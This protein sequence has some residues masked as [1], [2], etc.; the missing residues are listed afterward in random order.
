[1]SSVTRTGAPSRPRI[2]VV[3]IVAALATFWSFG[4]PLD[5][6]ATTAPTYAQMMQRVVD[7][8]NAIRVGVGLRP[9][10]R[11]AALDKVAADWARQQWQNG[12]MS[13]NPNF[14]TQIPSGW[15]RAGENVAKGYT[16][17][18]VV[19]A[20]KASSGHY[21]NIVNDYNSIGIGYFEQDGRRYWTQLFAKYPGVV[22]P[23]V[24][25]TPPVNTAAPTASGSRAIGSSWT[26]TN[27]T[28]TGTP[29]PSLQRTW[30]RCNQ[31]VTTASAAVPAGCAVISGATSAIYRS[32]AADAG[33]YLTV[34]I[35]ATNSTGTSTAV[36][37]TTV[38]TAATLLSIGLETYL[39]DVDGD[40]RADLLGRGK[41]G[42]L[43]MY[44]TTDAGPLLSSGIVTTG[45]AGYTAMIQA[46]DTDR[47]GLADVI[48]R[49]K[50]GT[51]WLFR[52]TGDAGMATFAPRVQ[53]ASGWQ[54]YL[55]VLSPGDVDGD[56]DPDVMTRDSA[57]RLWLFPGDGAG[58]LA[59]RV[60]AGSGWTGATAFVTP[61][62]F[63]LDGF[64][65]LIVRDR[66]GVLWLYRGNAEG[67][68][69]TT[70]TRLG[71]GW[72]YATAI[73][74][75]GDADSD[76]LPDLIGRGA[77]GILYRYA[78]N[79]LDALSPGMRIGTGWQNATFVL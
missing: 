12:T 33:K 2:V 52:G 48:T 55:S 49:D 13:H 74:S 66:V 11:N 58:G 43:V 35:K 31:A 42:N 28:W 65:D 68:F 67:T 77:T 15:S 1:L 63:D 4:V 60:Q 46:G 79:G 27:G 9:L 62:D 40:G 44:S 75:V 50:A 14:S 61:G 17:L 23:T 53:I 34:L 37:P 20:W 32:T 72:Q 57:G 24:A 56:G 16:Y 45:W 22:Q 19:P 38:A 41:T 3:A 10:V 47:D 64:P 69:S 5:A 73:L 51:V 26:A 18:Q 7:D 36:A 29:T 76:G 25:A 30:L 54:G 70:R 6:H 8:T 59:P 39:R 21:A 71:G 78:W